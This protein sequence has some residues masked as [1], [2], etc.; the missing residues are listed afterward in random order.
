[1]SQDLKK[2]LQQP[3]IPPSLITSF[4]KLQVSPSQMGA[5]ASTRQAQ[6]QIQQISASGITNV[7]QFIQKLASFPKLKKLDLKI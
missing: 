3:P 1:M 5:R 2:L 4:L 6:A 7:Q